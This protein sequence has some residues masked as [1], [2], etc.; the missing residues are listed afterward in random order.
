[1]NYLA[2]AFLSRHSPEAILGAV[3][4]DFVKGSVTTEFTA[5][6]R[7][8][9]V[10][11]R[12]IDRYTDSH[13]IPAASCALVSTPRRRFAPILI[14]VFY[15]HFLA[16]HWRDYCEQPL[17]EFAQE[18]YAVLLAQHE[19]L[20]APLQLVAPRMAANN[21]LC[22][23]AEVSGIDAAVNGIARRLE[24]YPRAAVVRGSVEELER[25][26]G[27]L[28]QHFGEF[29]PQL[30]R[31]VADWRHRS[32]IAMPPNLVGVMSAPPPLTIP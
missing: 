10:L 12:A 3:Y 24:R 11:H 14:D 30:I 4:G 8:G 32:T 9:I 28:E 19:Q 31:H 13:P 16:R 15:D 6:I 7:D 23:Y 29:F 21:W 26:Y 20:P 25:H 18:V 1:M 5:G 22:A 2:H 17:A 27:A